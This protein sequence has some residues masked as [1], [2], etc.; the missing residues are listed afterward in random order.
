MI[1]DMLARE[2]AVE[3]PPR[4][5]VSLVP[6]H[7]ETLILLGI[8]GRLVGRT[9][10]CVEPAGRI[11]GV[12]EVGGVKSPDVARIVALRPD[13][14]IAN[15]EENRKSDVERL[16]AAG[17]PVFLTYPRTVREGIDSIRR[18]GGAVGL[19]REAEALA[20]PCERALAGS[21]SGGDRGLPAQGKAARRARPRALCFIW[22]DP[23]MLVG[24]DTYIHDV[25]E[26]A[27]AANAGASFEGRYPKVGLAEAM[28]L[29]PDVVLLPDEP[30]EFGEAERADL[31]AFAAGPAVR[32]G[33]V[34]TLD[35]RMLSWYGPRIAAALPRLREILGT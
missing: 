20:A 4:R 32:D 15:R 31:A 3:W 23:W 10:F 33:R 14:V 26:Q 35:G 25:L 24:A 29:A 30:Y 34:V 5:V 13:L 21:S 2:V 28:A 27:G 9:R 22:K 7:T 12:P 8:G 18:L 19:E 17:V 1:A 11:Q 16:E 6:S